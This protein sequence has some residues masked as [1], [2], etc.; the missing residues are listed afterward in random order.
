MLL[1]EQVYVICLFW[2]AAQW[3]LA[4]QEDI[5]STKLIGN[6]QMLMATHHMTC[7]WVI[8]YSILLCRWITCD[9]TLSRIPSFSKCGFPSNTF[10]LFLVSP[11]WTSLYL[12]KLTTLRIISALCVNSSLLRGTKFGSIS[13]KGSRSDKPTPQRRPS[14]STKRLSLLIECNYLRVSR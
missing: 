13:N 11:T 8:P 4:L 12:C 2:R 1:F 14:A 10:F 9:E 6:S 5:W 7:F 3:M